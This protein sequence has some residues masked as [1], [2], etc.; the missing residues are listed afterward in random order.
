MLSPVGRV[1][2][3]E[4]GGETSESCIPPDMPGTKRRHDDPNLGGIKLRVRGW[5]RRREYLSIHCGTFDTCKYFAVS[6][7]VLWDVAF[8]R[9]ELGCFHRLFHTRV[10]ARRDGLV[11]F[12]SACEERAYVCLR[13]QP[14][15][16]RRGRKDHK[17][18]YFQR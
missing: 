12:F 3:L 6:R 5:R 7:Q 17:Y 13:G 1:W 9:R 4:L 8:W 2:S 15:F 11:E 16:D 14:V 18:M 10:G